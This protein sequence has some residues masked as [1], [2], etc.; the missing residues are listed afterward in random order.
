MPGRTF[1]PLSFKPRPL[2]LAIAL[3]LS[4]MAALA[5]DPGD[6]TD[7]AD[8]ANVLDQVV[9]TAAGFEQK[10]TD[11][12]AS[13]SLISREELQKRP[14]MTL[15][16]AVNDLEGIDVG[17]TSDK[18]GQKT[19]SIRGMGADYTLILIDGRRQNNHGDIYPNSFGGNQ[20]NHIP[21]LD[22]IERI[23]VI[24]GPASTLYGSDA[25]GGV[26]NIITRKVSDRWRGSATVTH[27][28]QEHSEF[29]SDSTL[30]FAVMGP[31][32][33]DTL[34]LTL[35][36]ARYERDASNPEYDTVYDPSG[37]PHER[38]LGFGGGGKTVDNHNQTVGISLAWT[39]TDNQ[40]VIVD[41]DSSEQVYDNT[42]YVNNLGTETYPLGTVDSIDTIWRATGGVVQPR[43]GYVDEQTFTATSGRSP[44]RA[45]GASATA[46]FRWPGSIPPTTAAPCPSPLPNASCCSRCIRAPATTKE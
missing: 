37:A 44:T 15:I 34:G 13:I 38:S 29:G 32:L 11:A 40:S 26:V 20:F 30:D 21:P 39:P 5:Q 24:R 46:S 4:P 7:G 8:D 6:A 45:T 33:G 12:P 9:V 23:E 19:I 43:V 1:R 42:P 27:N 2:A 25:L 22:M 41:A 17:E 14:Y 18:T 28:V 16:D 3:L 10:L 36:G 35:R 31:I